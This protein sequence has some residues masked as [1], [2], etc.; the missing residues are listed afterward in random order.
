LDS[1]YTEDH[2]DVLAIRRQVRDAQ[3]IADQQPPRRT[4]S[5]HAT[6]P[7]QQKLI[8]DLWTEKAT[9]DG[10]KAQA[11]ALQRQRDDV[12]ASLRAANEQDIHLAG[13]QRQ[14]DLLDSN[15]RKHRENL[16]Q[17]RI[18]HELRAQKISNVNVAQPATF[19]PRPVSPKRGLLLALAGVL[20]SGRLSQERGRGRRA[21]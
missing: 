7:A 13:L 12:L 14:V 19:D 3:A 17:V 21:A 9:V 1:R 2:P 10:L 16:D 11:A 6:H 18:D 5:R 4:Q 15:Y 20:A 8:V